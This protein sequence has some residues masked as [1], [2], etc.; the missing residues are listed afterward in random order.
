MSIRKSREIFTLPKENILNSLEQ[1]LRDKEITIVEEQAN[2][3]QVAI[4]PTNFVQTLIRI[5][6]E[7]GFFVDKEP[8]KQLDLIYPISDARFD[9]GKELQKGFIEIDEIPEGINP[10]RFVWF[11]TEVKDENSQ[12]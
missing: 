12:L 6:R 5:S 7:S 4:Q 2:F 3:P 9:N 11:A 1:F 8:I 10:E